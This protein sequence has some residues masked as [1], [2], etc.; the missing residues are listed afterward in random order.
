VLG[1]W[2]TNMDSLISEDIREHYE[3]RTVEWQW[4]MMRTL[5]T[6]V[7]DLNGTSRGQLRPFP[8]DTGRGTNNGPNDDLLFDH[9]TEM[10]RRPHGTMGPGLPVM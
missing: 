1:I 9:D 10:Q 6:D 5:Q 7:P 3:R 2:T 4:E 8:E